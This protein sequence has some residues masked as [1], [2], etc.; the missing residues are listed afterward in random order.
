[1]IGSNSSLNCGVRFSPMV[2]IGI[3]D[4]LIAVTDGLKGFPEAISAVFPQA[5]VQTYI[6]YLIRNSLDFVSC[7]D[8]K[9][10]VAELKTIYR[11]DNVEAAE[12]ALSKFENDAWGHKY[13][14]IA[15]SW[16]H[17]WSEIIPFFAFPHD[18]KRV[19]RI[20]RCE[21]LKVPVKQ[22]KGLDCGLTADRV[23]RDNLDGM[24]ATIRMSFQRS[25]R[26]YDCRATI[27]RSTTRAPSPP[28][29]GLRFFLPPHDETAFI[30]GVLIVRAAHAAGATAKARSITSTDDPCS[31][32]KHQP[33][34]LPAPAARSPRNTRRR[35]G[36][37]AR[38]RGRSIPRRCRA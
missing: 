36:R 38:R 22:P 9:L 3:E 12:R 4:A 16:R 32:A 27:V 20:W 13:P 7:K 25:R 6:A 23:Q 37:R 31:E 29:L 35:R 28:R 18:V 8:R 19:H 1:M 5:M 21:G 14:A 33:V 17:R 34:L 15:Q 26:K 11:A 30:N 2:S 24:A 10:V